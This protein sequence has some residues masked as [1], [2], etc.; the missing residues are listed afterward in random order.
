MNKRKKGR[1]REREGR[2]RGRK[3]KAVIEFPS[4]FYSMVEE[5]SVK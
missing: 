5:I 3:E 2:M 4:F 1:E